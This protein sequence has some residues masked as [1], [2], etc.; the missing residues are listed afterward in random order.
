LSPQYVLGIDSST[1]SCK[2]ALVDAE[3]GEVRALRRA[4]HPDGTQVDPAAWCAALADSAG[5]L[6]PQANAV[7]VAGQQHGM[8][9]LDADGGVVRPAVLWNDTSSAAQ[10]RQLVDELGGSQACADAVGSVMVASLTAA[11]LRWL[12]DTEPENA[13]RTEHVLL[14]HDYLS[15]QLGGRQEMTTDHGDASGTG[16]YSTT[17]RE[18]VPELAR[19]ALGHDVGLPRVAGPSEVVG[20][21]R[22]GAAIAAGT[23]DNMAAALG[24]GLRPGD[25]CVSIGTSGV[26]SAVVD[27]A[28]H[29]GSGLVSGF[30]DATGKNLP[31][32]CTL[33][34]ARVLE[35]G[36][37]LLGV[38][39]SEFARLA[40]SARPGAG[41]TVIL[42][43]LDGE[44]TP[45]RPEATGIMRGLTSATGREDLARAV[46]EGLLCSLQDA[47][48]A[49]E[50]ATGVP[51]Q[52]ILL[53]GGGSQ[54]E[55]LR[56]IAPQVFGVGVSV[57]APGEYVALGAARQAAWAL[58]GAEVPPVWPG[59]ASTVFEDTPQPHVYERYAEL[60]DRT[61]GWA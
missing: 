57:P 14:P 59:A 25:V 32:A 48:K 12:R 42:P 27:A 38:D 26:A 55:A 35:L 10:A 44:R 24:L 51:A 37:R 41:G 56:R 58:S 43:Y 47:V 8:V 21:T 1:Q 60:R 17:R 13:A 50:A 28:V 46:I 4:A 52:R 20:A 36:A 34:G 30:L 9:A 31:L 19:L 39:H 18:F 11:K 45:N 6:L 2:A 61:E 49:L 7:S 54:S 53:I 40:L 22:H 33:N 16:Y 15:W 5:G 23:G 3:T 29:D